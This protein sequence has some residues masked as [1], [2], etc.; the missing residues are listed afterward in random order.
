MPFRQ[1]IYHRADDDIELS[2]ALY[3][4][5]IALCAIQL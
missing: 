1:E 4:F 5:A 2:I 3:E